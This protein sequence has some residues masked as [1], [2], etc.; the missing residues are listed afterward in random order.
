MSALRDFQQVFAQALLEPSPAA[1]AQFGA[2]LAVYQNTVAKGLVDVLRANFPTV[3]R[4]IGDECFD[5]VALCYAHEQPPRQ[6]SLALYGAGFAEFVRATAPAQLMYL[7][8]VAQLDR[9]WTEA[10]FAADAP[11]L[12]AASLAELSP[13][14]LGAQTLQLH[15]ATRFGCF[16]YSAV[17]V[18][19][20][21]RPS[22]P[23]QELDIS[24]A[25][26]A[27]LITRPHGQVHIQP[28]SMAGYEFIRNLQLGANL[29]AAA[30][31]MLAVDAHADIAA[32]LALLLQAGAFCAKTNNEE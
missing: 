19:R 24:D 30:A 28:L 32:S 4:L 18:W 27:V 21:N 20:A 26:E 25:D 12:L 16:P 6:P 9:L 31:A 2:G 1:Q 5:A 15:P 7:F 17:T 14:Q 3:L 11:V 8:S 13:Q 22:E 29:A 23:L 10:H